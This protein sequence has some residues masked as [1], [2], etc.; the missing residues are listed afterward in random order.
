MVGWVTGKLERRVHHAVDSRHDAQRSPRLSTKRR[1]VL[2]VNPDHQRLVGACQDVDVVAACR[3][4]AFSERAHVTDALSRVG[5][6]VVI[7]AACTVHHRLDRRERPLVV[8]VRLE[9]DPELAGVDVHEL[10]AGHCATDVGA[11]LVDP[12]DGA[13]LAAE[14][15]RDPSHPRVRRPGRRVEA[16]EHVAVLELRDRGCIQERHRGESDDRRDA[17]D[18]QRRPR[19]SQEAPEGRPIARCECAQQRGV[20]R[21][22]SPREQCEAE[23]RGEGERNEHGRTHRERV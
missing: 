14:R 7:H 19:T 3:V 16:H 12:R 23:R 2:P 9:A 15:R 13:Q 4:V 17:D 22:G 21:N 11:H 10:V 20:A 6:D 8:G 18:N 5:G 1:E